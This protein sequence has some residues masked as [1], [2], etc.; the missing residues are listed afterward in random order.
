VVKNT[1]LAKLDLVEMQARV[2]QAKS[3][4]EKAQRDLERVK[5]LYRDNV[6]T[7]EQLQNANTALEMATADVSVAEFNLRH[8]AIYAPNKGKILKRLAEEGELLGAGTPVFLYGSFF[9]GWVIRA[10]VTDQQILRLRIGDAAQVFFDAYPQKIFAARVT[11]IEAVANPYTGT[12]EVEL[13]LKNSDFQLY[14][15]FVGKVRIM[16]ANS[17]TYSIIPVEALIEG[18]QKEGF[19]YEAIP[20]A[21]QVKKRNIKIDRIYGDFLLV[22]SGLEGVNEVVTLGSSYLSEN[23]L[24]DIIK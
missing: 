17:R 5:K 1:L 16:P 23:S 2:N 13:Q 18:A 11:E 12:F 14:S 15:G 9:D 24:I 22:T 10:G 20:D 8:A 3:A 6:V 19:V 4:Q 21:N 7:L